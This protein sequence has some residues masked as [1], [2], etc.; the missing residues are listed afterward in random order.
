MSPRWWR[1]KEWRR[2]RGKQCF[3]NE[4]L[5]F[6]RLMKI[7]DGSRIVVTI[8]MT[9]TTS[10]A[11]RMNEEFTMCVTTGYIL[12]DVTQFKSTSVTVPFNNLQVCYN[13]LESVLSP[14]ELTVMD[15]SSSVDGCVTTISYCLRSFS[16]YGTTHDNVVHTFNVMDTIHYVS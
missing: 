15:I 11:G 5:I 8:T 14:N 10:P 4:P 6:L 1:R 9:P 7:S 2:S 12:G 3:N 16:Q 13:D